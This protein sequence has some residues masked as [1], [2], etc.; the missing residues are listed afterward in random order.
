[1]AGRGD[2]SLPL[3][4]VSI[5]TRRG[6][7]RCDH[8]RFVLF[9]LVMGLAIVSFYIQMVCSANSIAVEDRTTTTALARTSKELKGR[10]RLLVQ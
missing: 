10:T 4:D 5:I 9:S 6:R 1:M 7:C 8:P 2:L 3:E